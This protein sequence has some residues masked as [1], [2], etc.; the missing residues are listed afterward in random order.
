MEIF[1]CVFDFGAPR[2]DGC[3]AFRK[4]V[5]CEAQSGRVFRKIQGIALESPL[6]KVHINRVTKSRTLTNMKCESV[7]IRMN[8]RIA[9]EMS[10]MTVA[11]GYMQRCE[12]NER[13]PFIFVMIGRAHVNADDYDAL[14][15]A[16]RIDMAYISAAIDR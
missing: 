9:T 10:G 14:G 12:T 16:G 13:S 6:T 3:S 5:F 2:P 8:R 4:M 11:V 15:L 7:E 1:G